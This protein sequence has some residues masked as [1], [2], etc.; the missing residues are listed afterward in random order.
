MNII[1]TATTVQEARVIRNATRAAGV[2]CV[3]KKLAKL[4]T[5]PKRGIQVAIWWEI[6]TA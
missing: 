2:A 6:R 1:A 3:A 4:Y 5:Q